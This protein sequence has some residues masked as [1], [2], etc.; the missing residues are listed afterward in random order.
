[1]GKCGRCASDFPRWQLDGNEPMPAGD[2]AGLRRKILV[3][4]PITVYNP[5]EKVIELQSIGESA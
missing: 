1:M 2:S 3:D 4:N 5:P